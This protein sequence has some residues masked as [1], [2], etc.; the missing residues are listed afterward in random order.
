MSPG[1]CSG[2][3]SAPSKPSAIDWRSSASPREV[4]ATTF[5][6]RILTNETPHGVTFPAIY[7]GLF[8]PF[9]GRVLSAVAGVIPAEFRRDGVRSPGP[10]GFVGRAVGLSG[11]RLPFTRALHLR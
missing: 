5:S 11:S 4:E 10:G 2:S 1:N 9:S 6:M 7:N 3:Y 8:L